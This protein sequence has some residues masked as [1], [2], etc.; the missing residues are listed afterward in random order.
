MRNVYRCKLN[1]LI[2]VGTCRASVIM[3]DDHKG[4]GGRAGE[5]TTT[6]RVL[7]LDLVNGVLVTKNSVY[8]FDPEA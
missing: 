7:T 2:N 3:I 8:I 4:M 1:G 6:S 5:P